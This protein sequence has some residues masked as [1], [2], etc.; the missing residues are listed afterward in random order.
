[1]VT[2]VRTG[3]PVA[4]VHAVDADAAGA[5]AA[6]LNAAFVIGERPP[7]AQPLVQRIGQP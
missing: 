7:Q 5:A 2:T 6:A 3:D 1:V 4:R